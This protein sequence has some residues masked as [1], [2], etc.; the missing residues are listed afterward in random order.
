VFAIKSLVEQNRLEDAAMRIEAFTADPTAVDLYTP[1]ADEM[2]F[3]KGYVELQNL[4]YEQA[5]K[6]LQNMLHL[7]PD[8]PQRLRV[9]ARQMLA[10]LQRRVPERLGDVADLMVYAGRRLGH[11]HTGEGV[12]DAQQRAIDLLD[13]LVEEAE[14]NERGGGGGSGGGSAGGQRSPQSPMEQSQLPGGGRQTENLRNTRRIRPGEAWGSMPPAERE[15]I[16]QSLRDSFPSRYRQLVEQ[17]YQELAKK[18]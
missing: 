8:A 10:E 3:L 11:D 2:A 16:L 4:K 7:Y 12:Q 14:Q 6:S 15:R 13:Q 1:Y 9:T 5:V 18:P 17:Y